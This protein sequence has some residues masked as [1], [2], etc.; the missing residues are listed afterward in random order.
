MGDRV[1]HDHCGLGRVVAVSEHYVTVDFGSA[2]TKQVTP[3]ARG[4]SIL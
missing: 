1:T 4:F 2:G 3:A